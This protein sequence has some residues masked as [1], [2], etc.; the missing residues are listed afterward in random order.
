[1][2]Y[3]VKMNPVNRFAPRAHRLPMPE[4]FNDPFFR[5][6]M[7]MAPV[8]RPHGMRVDVRETA[9]AYILEAELPGVALEDISLTVENDV[10]TIAAERKSATQE[11]RDGYVMRERRSGRVER[12][13]SLEGVV[14]D[15]IRA[16]SVNGILTVTLPKEKP[17]GARALRHI[18]IGTATPA[19][20]PAVESTTDTEA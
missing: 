1:M 18:P 19:A 9:E 12:R 16:D 14:Q 8:Q 3:T 7:G 4:V 15:G 6:V 10:L 2:M 5:S 11:E 17:D 13:F 20:L